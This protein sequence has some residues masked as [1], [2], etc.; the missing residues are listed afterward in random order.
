MTLFI[1]VAGEPLLEIFEFGGAKNIEGYCFSTYFPFYQFS[2][3]FKCAPK[4]DSGL[5]SQA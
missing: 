3:K 5:F 1:E 4:M 2:N